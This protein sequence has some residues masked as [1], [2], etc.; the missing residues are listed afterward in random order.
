MLKKQMRC[1]KTDEY[2]D[3]KIYKIYDFIPDE[4]AEKHNLIRIID[5]SGEDYLY[6]RSHFLEVNIIEESE[7]PA[8][9]GLP[10][11]YRNYIDEQGM[12][13]YMAW[14]FGV[15]PYE[16]K[17]PL[18]AAK[19]SKTM[20]IRS[21]TGISIYRP[22]RG[23]TA[24]IISAERAV[25]IYGFPLLADTAEHVSGIIKGTKYKRLEDRTKFI[26]RK[27]EITGCV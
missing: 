17:T 12:Q 9:D 14:V 4:L 10:D 15:K 27:T 5:D 2:S 24:D 23:T 16:Y 8:L 7:Y 13:N 18:D 6:P 25:K 3:C 26:P 20:F 11:P 1:M 19:K 21:D 22:H